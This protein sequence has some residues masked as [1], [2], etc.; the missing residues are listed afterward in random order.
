MNDNAPKNPLQNA[1]NQ[2]D[3]IKSRVKPGLG[4]K[5]ASSMG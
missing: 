1:L 5:T 3:A 2:F 4:G